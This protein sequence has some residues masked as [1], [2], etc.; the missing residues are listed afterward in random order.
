MD[1]RRLRLDQRNLLSNRDRV[2][3]GEGLGGVRAG[4]S[5]IHRAA[6][7]LDP[8]EVVAEVIELL[9]DTRLTGFADRDDTE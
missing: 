2:G 4:A 7:R 1:V 9:L 6:P 8:H 5:A 3:D